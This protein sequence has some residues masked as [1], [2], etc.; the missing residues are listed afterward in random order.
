MIKAPLGAIGQVDLGH[1][2][3]RKTDSR[4]KKSAGQPHFFSGKTRQRLNP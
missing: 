2:A 4:Q 3:L 1:G